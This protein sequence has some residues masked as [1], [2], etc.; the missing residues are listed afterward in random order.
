[1][2]NNVATYL[3]YANLQMA[4]EAALDKF[5]NQASVAALI[6]GNDRSSKFPTVLAD[7]FVADGQGWVVVAHQ[8]NTP[9]GFSGT[10]FRNKQTNELVMS[11]R[12]TEFSDDAT[13]DNEAANK[14]KRETD[15]LIE[16]NRFNA[17]V[18]DS[19]EGSAT[20]EEPFDARVSA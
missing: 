5:G 13:R 9:T 15:L 16:V 17:G 7:Q 1:M 10:L 2:T 11:F 18:P 20:N 19:G 4:A 14:L 8:S 12:S 6:F 3:K